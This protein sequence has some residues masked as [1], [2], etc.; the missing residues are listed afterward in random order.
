MSISLRTSKRFAAAWRQAPPAVAIAALVARGGGDGGA[1]L[2]A[3][4]RRRCLLIDYCCGARTDSGRPGRGGVACGA[5]RVLWRVLLWGRAR[6]ELWLRAGARLQLLRDAIQLHQPV[7]R[8]CARRT[9]TRCT[10][11]SR[12]FLVSYCH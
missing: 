11:V 9:A 5:K 8:R 4:G 3:A 7:M 12:V 10:L 1:G 2:G 6:A